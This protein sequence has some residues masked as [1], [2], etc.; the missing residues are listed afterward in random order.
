M[1][2]KKFRVTNF[3]SVNDS[4]WIDASDVTALIG[5]NEAGKTNL[6]LPLWKLNPSRSG[7]INLLDDMPR[8]R[9]AEMRTNPGDH[10]F[11]R[12]VFDLEDNERDIAERF[13]ADRLKTES[14]EVAR[15]YAGDYGFSFC[16]DRDFDL[17]KA[18]E[19]KAIENSETPTPSQDGGPNL[20]SQFQNILPK[21]VYYSNYG[22]LDAQIYLPHVVDNMKRTDLSAKEAAKTRTLRV[23]FDLVS[24]SPEEILE[25]ARANNVTERVNQ[26]GHS[27]GVLPKNSEQIELGDEQVR[28]RAALLQSASSKLTKSFK[29][30][31]KQGDYRFRLQADGNYFR[32]WV[33]DDRRPEEIE[34]ENRSTG[35]QWFLSFFLV[36]K[37]ESESTHANAVVLLDEPGHSLHPLAQRDLSSFFDNLSRTHQIVFTTHSPFMIEADRLDRVR[38][39]YVDDN[40]GTVASSNLAAARLKEGIKDTG[41]TY[42][43]HSALNLTVAESLLLGCI[44]IIVEGPSD[45]HYLSTIKSILIAKGKI[46]PKAELVFPPSGGAKTAK[47]IAGIL[48]GRDDTLPLVLLDGDTAGKQAAKSLEDTLYAGNKALIVTTDEFVGDLK[49]T[50]IED[51]F[52][53][54]LLIE[55][56]DRIERRADKE[57]EE[58]HENSKPIVPQI[59][60]WAA[61][62]KFALPNDWKVQLALGVKSKLLKNPDKYVTEDM[63]E[64]WTKMFERFLS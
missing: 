46:H 51:L 38:K 3:R 28:I 29:D 36:F 59:K 64:R 63:L 58:E 26:H 2:L 33:A 13:G 35:L 61:R 37:Y 11:I 55:V 48:M 8:S 42:A 41:A 47:I 45:Q 16:D 39:V 52:P 9:Y 14:I 34:L 7:Q 31:W 23:L 57:F 40:G 5:E 12:C 30:W 19:V 32:I 27:M 22:N 10:I 62:E 49:D 21:F 6:L 1:R 17:A 44:P 54:S 56:I 50:E 25:L 60:N 24:L 43:V 20:F 4:D 15:N 18:Y 53:S